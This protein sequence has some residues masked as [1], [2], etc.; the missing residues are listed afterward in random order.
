MAY[1][2]KK[3]RK[4]YEPKPVVKFGQDKFYNTAK[5]RKLSKAMRTEFIICPVCELRPSRITDHVVSRPDGADFDKD[6]LLPMCHHCHNVKRG[7]EANTNHPLVET[8]H[9][10]TEPKLVPVDKFDIVG[11]IRGKRSKYRLR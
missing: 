11:V 7:L 8:K 6:N 10:D 4:E 3:E 5:W 2:P 1:I 9:S